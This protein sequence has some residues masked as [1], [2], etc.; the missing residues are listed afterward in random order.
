MNTYAHITATTRFVGFHHWP[1][2]TSGE[3]AYLANRHRHEFHVTLMVRVMHDDRDIEFH[4]LRE[5]LD[6][7]AIPML[8]TTPDG[9]PVY[10]AAIELGAMSC[11]Q[12]AGR[13]LELCDQRW[14]GRPDSC[15]VFEDG[16]NGATVVVRDEPPVQW[17]AGVLQPGEGGSGALDVGAGGSGNFF[18]GDTPH[19][20]W[21]PAPGSVTIDTAEPITLSWDRGGFRV[22]K[23][24]RAT[25]GRLG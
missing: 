12:I 5:F 16:E 18:V 8:D 14:R 17:G 24:D 3:R 9:F 15:Q 20:A 1:C 2:P 13:L 25:D 23:A 19:F 6:T 22:G 7:E 11:E 4:D 10:G 21:G